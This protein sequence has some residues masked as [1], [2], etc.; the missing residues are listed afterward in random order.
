MRRSLSVWGVRGRA[1]TWTPREALRLTIS[2]R[3]NSWNWMA[4]T[5]QTRQP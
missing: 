1:G 3:K 2:V 4:S 5:P